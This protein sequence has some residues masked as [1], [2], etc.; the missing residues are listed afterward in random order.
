MVINSK[1]KNI[2]NH[3]NQKMNEPK[4]KFQTIAWIGKSLVESIF[5][6]GNVLFQ[7]GSIWHMVFV[8]Y[9]MWK[10]KALAMTWNK[11]AH[12]SHSMDKQMENS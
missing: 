7:Y 5:Q 6:D 9:F 10:G 4:S 11:S 2:P 3:N 1:Y 8:T 12:D